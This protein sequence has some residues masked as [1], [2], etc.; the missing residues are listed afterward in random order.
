MDAPVSQWHKA[1]EVHGLCRKNKK[2]VAKLFG[3]L[4]YSQDDQ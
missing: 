3:Q 1:F 4:L 2:T